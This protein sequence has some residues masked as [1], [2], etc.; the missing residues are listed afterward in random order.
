MRF[1][2]PSSSRIIRY[3]RHAFFSNVRGTLALVRIPNWIEY[4]IFA[5]LSVRSGFKRTACYAP[6]I[7]NSMIPANVSARLTPGSRFSQ[8]VTLFRENACGKSQDV[9]CLRERFGERAALA[10]RWRIKSWPV[11]R[12][13]SSSNEAFVAHLSSSSSVR[14]MR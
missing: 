10:V 13:Q 8:R 12:I 4:P 6:L 14:G 11:R 2:R 5:C 1:C 9:A 7:G 3:D